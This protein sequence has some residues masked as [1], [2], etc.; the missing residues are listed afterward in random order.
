MVL[1]GF[2]TLV[3]VTHVESAC[4]YWSC[5]FEMYGVAFVLC[6]MT[7]DQRTSIFAPCSGWYDLFH[8][9]YNLV[10]TEVNMKTFNDG[11]HIIHHSNSKLHWY[12]RSPYL[13]TF[14]VIR[15]KSNMCACEMKISEFI[16]WNLR[17]WLSAVH[18]FEPYTRYEIWISQCFMTFTNSSVVSYSCSRDLGTVRKI[19]VQTP[20]LM[21][22]DTVLFQPL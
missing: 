13:P 5:L 20:K 17:G 3:K 15:Y 22:G 1:N 19:I 16:L 7:D 12:G 21:I 14:H 6:S 10:N 11:Y 18:I 8:G 2:G 4:C 9:R